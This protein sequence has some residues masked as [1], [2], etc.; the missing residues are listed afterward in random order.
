ML[1][2]GK[3]LNYKYPFEGGVWYPG[4]DM[5]TNKTIH[6]LKLFF[7][8]LL[9]AYFIDFIMLCIGQRRLYVVFYLILNKKIEM[10]NYDHF[11]HGSRPKTYL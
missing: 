4:G 5:T 8:Q 2:Q 1:D 7:Y 3:A 10:L 9:P 11:Q 6:T